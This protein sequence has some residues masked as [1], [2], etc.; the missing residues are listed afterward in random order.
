VEVTSYPGTYLRF[1]NHFVND[2]T[3]EVTRDDP[4]LQPH[5]D[6]ERVDPDEIGES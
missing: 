3:G 6:W 1:W 2:D 5:P 4:R